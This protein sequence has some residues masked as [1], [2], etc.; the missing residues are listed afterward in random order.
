MFFRKKPK[1]EAPIVHV[2]DTDFDQQVLDRPGLIVVD[3]WAAWCS[4]CRV[5]APILDEVAVEFDG[6]GVRIVKVDTDQ[7]P[8]TSARF[9][10]RSIPTLIF[11]RDGEPLFQVTGLVSKP[12]LVRELNQLVS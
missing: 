9:E 3:F 1:I 12:T 10:I 6:R 11:F 4:P 5:M 7:A 2:G 8:E